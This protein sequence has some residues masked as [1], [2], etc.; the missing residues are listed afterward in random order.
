MAMPSP[1]PMRALLASSAE[2]LVRAR[3]T[4]ACTLVS[5]AC[6]VAAPMSAW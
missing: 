1:E 2:R 3:T 5:V 6:A 4:R